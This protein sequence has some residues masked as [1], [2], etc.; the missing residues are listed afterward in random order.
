MNLRKFEG[1]GHSGLCDIEMWVNV[2]AKM[3]SQN[4]V[5]EE[6]YLEVYSF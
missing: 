1:I 6:C 2:N 3:E 5:S 4:C